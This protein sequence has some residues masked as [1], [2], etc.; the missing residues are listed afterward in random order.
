MSRRIPLSWKS[1]TSWLE[2]M[3]F[4]RSR[5]PTLRSFYVWKLRH[6]IKLTMEFIDVAIIGGGPAGLTAANT[7]GR[8]LHTAVVFDS[9]NY[10]NARAPH[11]HIVPTWDYKD[12]EEF[13]SAA[14]REI[15]SCYKTIRFVDVGVAKA[16]KKNDSHFKV[17]DLDGKEWDF[18]KVILA[19][20][21]SSVYPNIE[22]YEELWAKRIFHCLFCHGYEDQGA[23]SSGVLVLSPISIPAVAIRMAENAAQLSDTVTLYTNGNRD[24]AVQLN[25]IVNSR[26]EVEPRQI[27]RLINNTAADS[28]TVEFTDGSS[29]EEKFLVHNPQTTIQGPLVDQLGIAT[30]AM[31]DISAQ[32]PIYQTSVRGVFAA[33]DCVTPYKVI[34]GALS[35]GCNAGVMASVQLQAEKYGHVPMF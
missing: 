2:T 24:M 22:G 5:I 34:P 33:G 31:G 21:S 14:R 13:R 32:A 25:P 6:S 26:F 29:K 28:A 15:E 9:K 4:K 23:A 20:G 17:F 27:K 35:S 11:M 1:R 19:V 16:E 8:Q 10:G 12:P 7:L 30:T 18:H 3:G